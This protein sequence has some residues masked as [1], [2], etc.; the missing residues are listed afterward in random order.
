MSMN[1]RLSRE[2]LAGHYMPASQLGGCLMRRLAARLRNPDTKCTFVEGDF[3]STTRIKRNVRP[4]PDVE[5]IGFDDLK[6]CVQLSEPSLRYYPSKGL[7]PRASHKVKNRNQWRVK[8]VQA[9]LDKQ[10]K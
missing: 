2:F 6:E 9:W 5:F 10:D 4:L 7:F 1:M 8:E 3:I